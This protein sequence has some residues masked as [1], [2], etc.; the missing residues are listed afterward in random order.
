MTLRL[1]R[2]RLYDLVW[3]K[4]MTRVAKDPGIS[5]VM[6]ARICS[7]KDVP[8]PPRGYWAN[9]GSSMKR[10]TYVKP[11]LPDLNFGVSGFNRL[12]IAEYEQ[13]EA[14]RTDRFDWSNL[15]EPVPEP[16]EELERSEEEVMARL[17]E[18]LPEIPEPSS[19]ENLHPIAQKIY[20]QGRQNGGVRASRFRRLFG[21]WLS[22]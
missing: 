13:R 8:R 19:Y 16:P 12:V 4:L 3:A 21:P 1:T 11:P 6:L 10:R 7:Q 17:A 14:A 22:E 18:K 15:E 5:D 20:D 2:E 9:L